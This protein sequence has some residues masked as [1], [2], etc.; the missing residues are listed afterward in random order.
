MPSR[1]DAADR[2]ILSLLQADAH[3]KLDALADA[4]GL[5]VATVQRRIARMRRDGTIR[6]AVTLLDPDRLDQRMTLIVAVEMERERPDQLDAFAR[7][8][9]AEPNVRRFRTSVAMRTYKR[10]LDVPVR[11]RLR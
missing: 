4:A 7:A 2:T 9:C 10:S 8:A 6:G 1:L 3:A 11:D 5:S